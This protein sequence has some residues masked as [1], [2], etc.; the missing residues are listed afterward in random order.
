MIVRDPPSTSS[1]GLRHET[2][3]ARALTRAIGFAR[4]H[5]LL[6]A[7]LV[8]NVI[9][10][11]LPFY[12]ANNIPLLLSSA[13]HFNNYIPGFSFLTWAVGPF[14]T[15]IYVP[16]YLAYV[17]SGYSLYWSYTVLKLIFLGLTLVLSLAVWNAMSRRSRTLATA[18]VLFTLANPVWFMVNYVW[19]EFDIFPV[20]FLALGYV[21]LRYPP[22]Q[23]DPHKRV[24]LATACLTVS[25]FFYWF[26]AA[27]LPALLYY[28]KDKQERKLLLSYVL[29]FAT[30]LAALM[31]F[32]LSANVGQIASDLLG[33][34]SPINR[35]QYFGFQYFVPLATWEYIAAVALVTIGVPWVLRWRHVPEAATLFT[36]LGLILYTSPVPMPDNYVAVFPFAVLAVLESSAYG[37]AW[38]RLWAS[39]AFPLTGL[40]LINFYISNAQPDGVGIFYWGYSIFG[41]NVQFLTTPGA[42]AR[43]LLL[44]N[45][46]ITLALVLSI[47]TV[48]ALCRR[49]IPVERAA[50]AG[51]RPRLVQ[52]GLPAQVRSGFA[53][54]RQVTV[55]VVL[56]IL[57][58]GSLAFNAS[59]S[60][61]VRY[62]G[63]GTAPTYLVMPRFV[64][65]NGNVVRPIPGQTYA[66][67][68]SRFYI[69]QSASP[70]QFGRWF[71][72]QDVGLSMSQTL[73]GPI[74]A[75]VRILNAT[76]LSVSLLN[77]TQPNVGVGSVLPANRTSNLSAPVPSPVP[78]LG[79]DR[80][81]SNYTGN[82]TTYYDW[83]S[84]ATFVNRYYALAFNIREL[85]PDGTD[86]IHIQGADNFVAVVAYPGSAVL[87]YGG[88]ASNGSFVQSYFTMPVEPGGWTYVVFHPTSS[89]FEV[90]LG[91]ATLAIDKPLFASGSVELRVGEPFATNGQNYSL[92]G[93]AT[94]V[95]VKATNW[96]LSTL[97]EAE[98]FGS[99]VTNFLSLSSPE[100]NISV[101]SDSK[102]STLGVS[103]ELYTSSAPLTQLWFGKLTAGKYS[104][105]FSISSL[106]IVQSLTGNFDLVPI[107]WLTVVP[108]MVIYTAILSLLPERSSSLHTLR[109]VK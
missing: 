32:A 87:V 11:F 46:S 31:I 82:A 33:G 100:L 23:A 36:V 95:Y 69:P 14:I 55:L 10:A 40:F 12:D 43:F 54:G 56:L 77:L 37:P 21:L 20:M 45:I 38:G 13:S 104:T 1:Q 98:V 78:L 101:S 22:P 107:F 73:A 19:V 9:V 76:P 5:P 97:Y 109:S 62:N 24:I 88:M 70:I 58:A 3:P 17:G 51:P 39:I 68:G 48:L 49:P 65:D 41:A 84:T 18:A 79:R 96:N 53:R 8:F 28:S 105:R 59:Y 61:L 15:A 16:V 85:A 7:V 80:L 108:Y 30:I 63:Q 44:Y 25:I 89:D 64:P 75:L 90:D 50:P 91:G 52:G 102:R 103:G 93:L 47:I 92:V 34:S 67:S 74:P 57:V 106:T 94:D 83:V 86:I 29:A 60:S 42:E 2:W 72:G 27:V 6:T 71:D 66:Q 81:V 26:A 35:A 99:S 4:A